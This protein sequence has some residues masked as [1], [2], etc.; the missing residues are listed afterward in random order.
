VALDAEAFSLQRIPPPP[1]RAFAVARIKGTV[2][3]TL[4][5]F[6]HDVATASGMEGW[7]HEGQRNGARKNDKPTGARLKLWID[8]VS[9]ATLPLL[10]GLST[11]SVIVVSDDDDGRGWPPRE[12]A[13]NQERF[14]FNSVGVSAWML[15]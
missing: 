3:P 8:S 5:S 15:T 14:R 1:P 13:D 11:T 9:S 4:H 10:A 2:P 12:D 6:L 7:H